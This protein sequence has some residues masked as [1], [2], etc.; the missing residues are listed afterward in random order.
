MSGMVSLSRFVRQTG[1]SLLH[2]RRA[3][4]WLIVSDTLL[5]GARYAFILY[6]GYCSISML[7]SFLFGAALGALLAVLVD[8]GINQHWIR[9]KPRILL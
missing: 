7:G 1:S 5:Q 6:V 8:F 3:A 4:L 9:L 2:L